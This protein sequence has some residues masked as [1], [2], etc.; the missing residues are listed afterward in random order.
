MKTKT[1]RGPLTQVLEVGPPVR[2]H[3]KCAT[4]SKEG[5]CAGR[6]VDGLRPAMRAHF[7]ESP[8]CKLPRL[9]LK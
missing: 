8:S 5:V 6:P 7:V 9:T 1:R 4:C 2:Y 3:W